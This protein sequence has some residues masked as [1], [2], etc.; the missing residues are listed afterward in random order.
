MPP[1][2]NRTEASG[3]RFAVRALRHRNYRL[4][5]SG[6]SI[7]LAGSWM[8][9]VATSWLVYKLSGSA[10]LLGVI[11]FAGQL[12]QFILGP[13]AGVWIDR[14]D[15]HKVLVW[16]QVLSMVQSLALAALALTNRIT[17]SDIFWLS[18][19]QGVINAIDM[20]ARQAFLTEMVESRDDIPNAIA[21]NASM[22][23]G[24]RLIGP[25][26]AGLIIAVS[27]EGVCFL[28]DGISY[29]AVIVSLL[30]MTLQLRER[31]P[32][33]K[34]AI[35]EM[36]E[37]WHYVVRSVP[38]RSIL[39]LLALVSFV[40]MPYTVLLPIFAANILHGGAHTLG[41][42]MGAM[43]VGALI[44]AYQLATRKTVLGLGRVIAFTSALFGVALVGFA[45]SHWLW[46]SLILML[47]T[48]YGIM[49]Q[50]A[51]SNTILQTI[52]DEDVRGRVMS[53]YVMA[54]AGTAP[55]GSLA[56]GFVAQW[57]GAPATLVIGGIFCVA[58]AIWFQRRLPRIRNDVRPIYE[59]L[60]I[61]AALAVGVDTAT[62]LQ[63][64]TER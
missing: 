56:A 52:V 48:G 45:L 14:L 21:L 46:L 22:V 31:K 32:S 24:A 44:S 18:I 1:D 50:M 9:R 4:F 28:I 40:G 49:Q 36:R 2:D 47:V 43:G 55:F 61:I 29:I 10:M 39:L 5:F 54:F 62:N 59:R 41:F 19:L 23:N 33:T 26:I 30:M 51:S 7:S 27:N 25:S 34:S 3:W 60:G 37:G 6:Q 8:T 15:R 20:P 11:G 38:V 35:V 42:L 16:T 13:I 53:F 12:P 57:I 64:E 63:V 58:G 17:Y